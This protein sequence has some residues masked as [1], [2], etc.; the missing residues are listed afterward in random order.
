MLYATLPTMLDLSGKTVIITG[1]N[2]GI[3]KITAAA[4][5]K[6]G[7]HVVV[8]CRSKEKTEPVIAEIRASAGH[9]RV[10][11]VGCDLS[12]L[13][14]VRQAADGLLQRALPIHVLINNAGLA[15]KPGL[16]KDGFEITFGTNHLG[17]YLW[18]RL[19]QPALV[20]TDAAAPARI[21]NVASKAHYQ[22]KSIDWAAQRERTKSRTG[23]TEYSVSKL[24]N[25]LF[26]KELARRAGD[27]ALRT[28]A[29]HP[30][31]VATDVWR[32]VPSPFRWVIK[33]FMITPEQGAATSIKTAADPAL[34]NQTGR[35]Y[36]ADGREK[37][38]SRL[39]DDTEL[40]RELWNRSAQWVGLPE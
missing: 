18:T 16:T 24:C 23:L 22:A 19:L 3:G 6:R 14:S 20:T 2:T 15:G 27:Q 12:D 5:A 9:D 1:A 40:A 35:Y 33:K 25:V 37:N 13:A 10:E 17:H 28:Y 36:D 31:V 30:G 32:H 8:A 34:A 39:A 11:W 26:T 7:A 38:T 29:L 4:L 21:V